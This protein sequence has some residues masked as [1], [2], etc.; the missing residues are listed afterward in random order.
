MD[1]KDYGVH[2]NTSI[3]AALDKLI[4]L[5]SPPSRLALPTAETRGFV[6]ERLAAWKMDILAYA[7]AAHGHDPERRADFCAHLE[8]LHEWLQSAI[9]GGYAMHCDV[10][11][12][13]VSLVSP[14][15]L[16]SS[17]L[18]KNRFFV[19]REQMCADFSGGQVR[20]HP[21]HV[22]RLLGQFC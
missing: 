19:C 10:Y 5:A 13:L 16:S 11:I 15:A 9:D 7:D 1:Q 17:A 4:C 8:D 14:G 18:T 3:G 21:F 2:T 22:S 20:V 6:V 12:A